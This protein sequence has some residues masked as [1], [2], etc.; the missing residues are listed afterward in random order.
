MLSGITN[1]WYFGIPNTVTVQAIDSNGDSR[2][3]GGDTVVL[4]VEQ[5]CTL[6]ASYACVLSA[7]QDNVDGLPLSLD[8]TDNGDGTYQADV[9]VG[10]VGTVTM[11]ATIFMPQIYGEYY[12]NYTWEDPPTEVRYDS[13]IAN[14]YG[15]SPVGPLST[16]SRTT[17]RWTG[18]ISAPVAGD[19]TIKVLADDY[20][21]LW[22]GDP[23]HVESGGTNYYNVWYLTETPQDFEFKYRNYGGGAWAKMWWESP[24]IPE[25]YIP[26]SAF[27]HFGRVGDAVHQVEILKP[28]VADPTAIAVNFPATTFANEPVPMLLKSYD[29][30]GLE[31]DIPEDTFEIEVIRTD[32]D[33]TEPISATASY[34]GDS[35]YETSFVPTDPGVYSVRITYVSSFDSSEVE[36]EGS[37]FVIEVATDPAILFNST[38]SEVVTDPAILLS[39]TSTSEE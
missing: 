15:Y 3:S 34:I 30:D 22:I 11:S 4:L 18:T 27:G 39:S 9:T 23:D 10:G 36:I 24:T 28:D 8:M 38:T 5:L 21:E 29:S 13:Q 37:P 33:S 32:G 31:A 14:H 12:E 35:L 26:E 20:F 25:E 7:E 17:A 6:D 19:Y 16:A 2:T 1:D